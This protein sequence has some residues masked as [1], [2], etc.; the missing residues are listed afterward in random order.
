MRAPKQNAFFRNIFDASSLSLGF[1]A[2]AACQE[3][4]LFFGR[5]MG[6]TACD[7]CRGLL[8]KYES[9][10]ESRAPALFSRQ[11]SFSFVPY[12]GRGQSNDPRVRPL[13]R[14]KTPLFHVSG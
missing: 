2:G 8:S 13:C 10:V 6:T 5:K 4:V 3:R 11:R 12:W 14:R 1:F 7:E 9:G